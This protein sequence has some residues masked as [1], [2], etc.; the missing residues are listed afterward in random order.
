MLFFSRLYSIWIDL[1]ALLFYSVLLG[2]E[3]KSG[4]ALLFDILS[5]FKCRTHCPCCSV[6]W[7]KVPYLFK[8][9]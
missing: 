5:V 1:R 4:N 2:A 9:I 7:K 6:L 8:Y 3:I